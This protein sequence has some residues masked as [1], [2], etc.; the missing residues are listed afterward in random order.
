MDKLTL[1]DLELAGKRVLVRVDFNVPTGENG[2]ITDDRRIREALPTIQEL[3]RRGAKVIACSHFGRPKGKVVEEY[4]LDRVARRLSE[5]LGQAVMKVNDCVGEEPKRA[6]A[7]MKP[8]EVLLLENVRFYPEEEQN[9]PHFAR[10]LA[11][12][13]D[14]YVNDA[15]GA[16]HRAHASTAGV[17]A[18]LPAAAGLL[19]ERE[20]RILGEA[21]ENPA[22]PFVTLLGGK[23]VEDKIGV[24]DNLLGKVDALLVGGGMAFTFLKAQGYDVGKSLVDEARLDYARRCLEEAGRRRVRL[25]LPVDVVVAREISDDAPAQVVAANAIPEGWMGLDIGPRTAENFAAEICGARTVIW[26]GPVGVFEVEA[27]SAGTLAMCQALSQVE[28]TTIVGG[29][30]TAAAVEHFG[31]ADK[32]THIST[33]GGASLEFLEGKELPGVAALSPR[34]AAQSGR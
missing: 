28:G 3:A 10:E 9:D 20:L 15:F 21:L 11:S 26:N 2:E 31:F 27:F 19:L 8:G 23:K 13:A 5:L 34:P 33:G 1:R 30:D 32:V 17:A 6:I 25:L 12:L 22:R 18:Y 29:G 24:I 4:R 14:V 16:A 7:A